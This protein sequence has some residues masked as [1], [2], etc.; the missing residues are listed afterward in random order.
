MLIHQSTK[1]SQIRDCVAFPKKY[2]KRLAAAAVNAA[3][4]QV[5]H[6]SVQ[7]CGEEWTLLFSGEFS[8]QLID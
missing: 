4:K 6:V 2:E 3:K 7:P 1:S 5:R 8:M